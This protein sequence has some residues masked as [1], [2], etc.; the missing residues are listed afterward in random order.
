MALHQA[1][2]KLQK[3]YNQ[4]Y[5]KREKDFIELLHLVSEKG[6]ERIEEAIRTLETV[7]PLDIT[8]EKVKTICNRQNNVE[9]SDYQNNRLKETDITLKAGEMLKAFKGLIPASDEEFK[10][11]VAII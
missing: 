6:I 5:I 11:E 4:Y 1:D 3:I 2:P 8:T 9:R 7:S 10:K